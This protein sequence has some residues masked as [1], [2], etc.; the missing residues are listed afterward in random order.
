[1]NKDKGIP[2]IKKV[3]ICLMAIIMVMISCSLPVY[4]V[5][6]TFVN[7]TELPAATA[8][9]SEGVN[10]NFI[11]AVNNYIDELRE[12]GYKV[13]SKELDI[14]AIARSTMNIKKSS[15]TPDSD[16]IKKII[17]INI[18]ATELTINTETFYFKNST[19]ALVFVNKLNEQVK[20]EYSIIENVEIDI[21]K[22]TSQEILDKKI[23][24]AEKERQKIEQ[25]QRQRELAQKK[26]KQR[27]RTQVSSRGGVNKIS[28]SPPIVSYTYISSYYGARW[29]STHTGVDFAA[30]LGTEIYAWKAG[31]VTYKGWRGGYG[32][33]VEIT[34]NDGTVSRYAHMSRYNCS[35]G[36]IVSAGSTIGYVGSTGNST[37][38]HLHWEIKINGAFVNPLNYL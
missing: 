10:N 14:E 6:N 23:T 19:D 21:N 24:E 8:L 13:I 25:E 28:A 27:D 12:N 7:K 17:K 38:P 11:L 30:P 15:S 3:L 37:G 9:V 31:K 22:T 34:H 16:F 2:L 1:M 35:L 33:F 36:D 18:S 29:G 32:N 5:Q 20:T 26:K 4:S